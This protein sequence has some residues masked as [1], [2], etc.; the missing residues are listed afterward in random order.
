MNT[1]VVSPFMFY[2][3]KSVSPTAANLRSMT[4]AFPDEALAHESSFN[5]DFGPVIAQPNRWLPQQRLMHVLLPSAHTD[6]EHAAPI[7]E[8][9][10]QFLSELGENFLE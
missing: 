6:G 8:L 4:T 1:V 3:E 7:Q 2:E 5:R 9:L 10:R